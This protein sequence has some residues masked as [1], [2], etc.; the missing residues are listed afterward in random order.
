[1]A[2]ARAHGCSG[3]SAAQTG[4]GSQGPSSARPLTEPHPRG[5]GG[6][7][8]FRQPA[9]PH[10]PA[11]LLGK[12]KGAASLPTPSSFHNQPGRVP[13]SGRVSER[14]GPAARPDLTL[15]PRDPARAC[16]QHVRQGPACPPRTSPEDPLDRRHP[17]TSAPTAAALRLRG[18]RSAFTSATP[19]PRTTACRVHSHC[20]FSAPGNTLGGNT[21]GAIFAPDTE[22]PSWAPGPLPANTD[23]CSTSR[24][25]A[26]ATGRGE[27]PG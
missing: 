5:S 11:P 27:A 21:E 12:T 3:D 24:R 20:P 9:R 2:R 4:P 10:P 7:G 16:P 15:Q 19:S 17:H 18:A 23:T 6:G 26:G 25:G 8:L 13:P 22:T 1:M 14:P